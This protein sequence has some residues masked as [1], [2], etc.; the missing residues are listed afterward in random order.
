MPALFVLAVVVIGGDP[1]GP[2]TASLEAVCEDRSR[3]YL[4]TLASD[5]DC[6]G[7]DNQLKLFSYGRCCGGATTLAP[8]FVSPAM[9]MWCLLCC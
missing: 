1:W 3:R 4:L 2:A 9:V 5:Q 7:S 8:R 6:I